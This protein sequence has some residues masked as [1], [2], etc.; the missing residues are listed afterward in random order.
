MSIKLGTFL[1]QHAK[2]V[3]GRDVPVVA[4]AVEQIGYES[5]WA[6]ERP[7][8]PTPTRQPLFG[9]PG[10]D[11]PEYYRGLADPMITLT[12][13]GAV[14]E[15]AR[16]G[17][18]ILIA[19]LHQPFNV[20]MALAALDN[21]TNGRAV[22]GFGTGWSVD[23]YAAASV[24][25]MEQRGEVLDEILD[26]CAAVWGP[27][28]VS[29]QG[30]LVTIN[31]SEVRPKPISPIPV[32]LAASG[33]AALRRVAKRADG[34]MPVLM[35]AEGFAAGRRELEDMAAAAGRDRP[36]EIIARA[37]ADYSATPVASE[38]RQAF[39]GNVEQIVEDLAAHTAVGGIGEV[40]IDLTLHVWD[41][42]ELVDVA[43]AVY[44][45]AREAGI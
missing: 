31:P 28:P 13:A 32:I 1:P 14:T 36:I 45:A 19:G 10:L 3:I 20:A 9:I 44:T 25:P 4:P 5:L 29:Y 2:F 21:A 7:L 30:N 39:H 42:H 16:V 43:G 35:G 12:L 40:I 23:E 11:W 37:N 41:A 22:A 24:A 38:G 33:G 17:S 34:W 26:V 27:D 6:T 8:F 18:S 15:R